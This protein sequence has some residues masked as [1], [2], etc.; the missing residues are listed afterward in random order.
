MTKTISIERKATLY[1][2]IDGDC[3]IVATRREVFQIM[4]K[5][6]MD[7]TAENIR[8]KRRLERMTLASRQRAKSLARMHRAA[9]ALR[10]RAKSAESRLDS[11]CYITRDP[12]G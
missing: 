5:Q 8:L 2:H 10:I 11:I 6:T 4:A 9:K 1:W 7:I 3:P 12:N